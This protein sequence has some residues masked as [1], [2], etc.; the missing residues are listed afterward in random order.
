MSQTP[1][2]VWAYAQYNL[3][4][5]LSFYAMG[6]VEQNQSY[7]SPY[8][9]GFGMYDSNMFAFGMNYKISEKTSIGFRFDFEN[10]NNPFRNYSRSFGFG[11]PFYY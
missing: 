6:S 9:M 1:L 7:F 11:N 8:S 5:K 4:N 2:Q 3:N 10:S